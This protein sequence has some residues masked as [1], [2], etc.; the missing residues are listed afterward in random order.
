MADNLTSTGGKILESNDQTSLLALLD[1]GAA[2]SYGT[3]NEPCNYPQKFPS[4][5]NHFYQARGFSIAECYYQSVTNPY[6]GLLVG[7]PLAAPFAVQPTAAWR[8]LP[9]NPVLSGTTNLSLQVQAFDSRHPV[10]QLDLFVDGTFASTLTNVAPR[11]NN[12]VN[13]TI[14]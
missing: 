11:P 1:V 2:A 14:N 9:L 5:Q 6:Q 7:E 13:A 10:Q 3:V 8:S 4:P 12:I